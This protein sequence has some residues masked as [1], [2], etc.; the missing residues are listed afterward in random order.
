V[1]ARKETALEFFADISDHRCHRYVRSH[2]HRVRSIPAIKLCKIITLKHLYGQQ[3]VIILRLVLMSPRNQLPS[4]QWLTRAILISYAARGTET[5]TSG[6]WTGVTV[7]ARPF[8][9]PG[10]VRAWQRAWAFC[11]PSK[12]WVARI[13]HDPRAPERDPSTVHPHESD[14]I[15]R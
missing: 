9:A 10:T 7:R 2:D 13:H 12:G 15:G 14:R 3:G 6:H 5:L 11:I 8:E 1:L 4:C